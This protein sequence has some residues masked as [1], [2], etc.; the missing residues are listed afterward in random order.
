MRARI[1]VAGPYTKF[2]SVFKAVDAIASD[3]RLSDENDESR[4]DRR[5]IYL[6]DRSTEPGCAGCVRIGTGIVEHTT[7]C[8]A[9]LEEVLCGVR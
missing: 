9:V 1:Y 4:P 5:G 2:L 7:R 8:I 6:R 3:T